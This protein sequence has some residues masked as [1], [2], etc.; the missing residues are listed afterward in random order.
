[1]VSRSGCGESGNGDSS[2]G[3]LTPDARHILYTSYSTNPVP[4]DATPVR[5]V[6]HRP[7]Q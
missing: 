6:R 4:D 2:N 1:M 7:A 3:P 5:P